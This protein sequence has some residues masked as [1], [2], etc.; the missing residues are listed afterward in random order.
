MIAIPMG[1]RLQKFPGSGCPNPK[2]CDVVS[3]IVVDMD[4]DMDA[5]VDAEDGGWTH[6]TTTRSLFLLDVQHYRYQHLLLK[7]IKRRVESTQVSSF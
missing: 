6:C 3:N 1:G 4:K 5:D 2:K 7:T